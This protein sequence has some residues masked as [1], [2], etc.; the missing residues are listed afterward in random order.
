MVIL[1]NPIKVDGASLKDHRM[2][3]FQDSCTRHAELATARDQEELGRGH[4][5][6]LN[7]IASATSRPSTQI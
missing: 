1:K 7:S 3:N 4:L 2:K 5:T 6:H